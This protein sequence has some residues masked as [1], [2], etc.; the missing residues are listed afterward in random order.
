MTLHVC[1]CTVQ[2]YDKENSHWYAVPKITRNFL[3]TS[4]KAL[5]LVSKSKVIHRKWV[6]VWVV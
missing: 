3:E 2:I 6:W 4:K 5:R 1:V